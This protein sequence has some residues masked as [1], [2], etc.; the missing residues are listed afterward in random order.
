MLRTCEQRLPTDRCR[1]ICVPA[2]SSGG[3][4]RATV[5]SVGEV[6]SDTDKRVVDRFLTHYQER[7]GYD[8]ETVRRIPIELYPSLA[9]RLEVV[10]VGGRKIVLRRELPR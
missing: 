3:G 6:L 1:T 9:L 8:P 5:G 7:R 10:D 2:H 4:V